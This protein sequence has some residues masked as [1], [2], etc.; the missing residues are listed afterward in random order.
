MNLLS[1][2]KKLPL[3]SGVYLFLDKKGRILYVGRAISLRKRV[4]N[5]FRK[6]L[7]PRI[8]EMVSLATKIKCQ[9]TETILEAIISE[10]NLIKKYWPKYNVREK[11]NRSF[12]YLIIPKTDFPRPLIVRQREL[13]KF[14]SARAFIFGPYQS[15]SLLKNALRIIRRIFPY[16][17][18]QPFS[19]KPCF[20]YQIG[21]C[22]GL[23]LGKITKK[24]YQKNIKNI[25]LLLS[26]R[27]KRLFKKLKKENP[28]KARGLK[29][30]QD[31]SLILKEEFSLISKINR[32]E[33]YDISHL[34]GKEPIG[35]MVVFINGQPDNSQYRLFKIKEAPK[36]D[37]LRALAEVIKRR[38]NHPE[39]PW[40]DLI[41]ID[42]G[43]PQINYISK[44]LK[45]RQLNIPLIGISKFKKDKLVFPPKTKKSLK[46]LAQNIKPILLRV[47]NEAHRFCLK[48]SRHQRKIKK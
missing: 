47:R 18:C 24:D 13:Q 4:M 36:N 12:I 43:R 8:K 38:F 21:L 11:D 48:S 44:I 16:G 39:W 25:I 14:P 19:G 26:D 15:I 28:E 20:N 40:P 22:P 30:L 35:A 17:T 23:C 33:G 7:D 42:G 29:H 2:A 34:T 5:Y 27:K 31:V 45:N 3:S 9:K 46:E 32:I 41:L 1:Q 6:D 37:D 10:A